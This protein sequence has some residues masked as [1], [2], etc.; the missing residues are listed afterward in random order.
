MIIGIC[1]E[2]D[3]DEELKMY[4]HEH[5]YETLGRWIRMADE[6]CQPNFGESPE[7]NELIDRWQKNV[8]EPGVFDHRCIQALHDLIATQ[9]RKLLIDKPFSTYRKKNEWR[10]FFNSEAGAY[11]ENEEFL[12]LFIKSLA[13]SGSDSGYE[14]EDKLYELLQQR[15]G[16]AAT[17]CNQVDNKGRNQ[18]NLETYNR[19]FITVMAE[20]CMATYAW[21]N[22]TG[23]IEEGLGSPI[24]SEPCPLTF[25]DYSISV[26]LDDALVKWADFYEQNSDKKSFNWKAFDSEGVK[27]ANLLKKEV[28]NRIDVWYES[29]STFF[30]NGEIRTYI[31][32]DKKMKTDSVRA[33]VKEYL[34][35]IAPLSPVT[36]DNLYPQFAQEQS[37]SV[38]AALYGLSVGTPVSERNCPSKY[39]AIRLNLSDKEIFLSLPGVASNDLKKDIISKERTENIIEGLQSKYGKESIDYWVQSAQHRSVVLAAP[40]MRIAKKR[41]NKT[42]LLCKIEGR[43]TTQ[44]VSACHIV[45]RKTLFWAA[46]DEVDRFMGT[47][48]SDVA[49]CALKEKLKTSELHS[50]PKYIVTLCCE[51]DRTLQ[52][53]LTGSVT[54]QHKSKKLKSTPLFDASKES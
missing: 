2:G 12:K 15:Y 43:E 10:A 47:I 53:A 48:F 37:H 1:F 27:L 41:D 33:R 3:S 9:H 18:K 54:R 35:N 44:A 46:L 30:C 42:C 40:G 21:L 32:E 17:E 5:Y 7:W 31:T 36:L 20:H 16:L 51:H 29:H 22:S 38:R 39:Y 8:M 45:S 50:N 13:F 25:G 52:T 6:K 23:K 19:P 28:K 11:L 24:G 4:Q 34:A 26:A 14:S 49:V